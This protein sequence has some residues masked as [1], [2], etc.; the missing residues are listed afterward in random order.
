MRSVADATLKFFREGLDN[1]RASAPEIW[2]D[3]F[4]AEWGGL[5]GQLAPMLKDSGFSGEKE[6]RI[7]HQLHLSEMSH[8][9]FRQ[10]ATLM[11][12]HLPLVF[13]LV[14]AATPSRVLP[15]IEV[16][17]GPSRHKEITRVSVDAFMRQRGYTVPV[18]ISE[19]PFQMT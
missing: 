11:S 17:V 15:I 19:I 18:S 8:L 2:A 4:I 5:I 7:V 13:P 10:K 3:E 6:Y 1:N 12:R 9:Q 14:G 16:M